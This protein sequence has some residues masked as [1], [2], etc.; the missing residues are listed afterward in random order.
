VNGCGVDNPTLNIDSSGAK[1]IRTGSANA[2]KN[3]F[4]L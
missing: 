4:A 3:T 2:N 1:A